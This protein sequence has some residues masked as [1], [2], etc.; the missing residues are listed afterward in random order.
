MRLDINHA[1]AITRENR[2]CKNSKLEII[3]FRYF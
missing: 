1:H 2:F 3:V